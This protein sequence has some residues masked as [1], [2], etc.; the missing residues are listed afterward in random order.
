MK[1]VVILGGGILG[2][3]LQHQS[4]WNLL[5]RKQDGFDITDTTAFSLLLTPVE[6]SNSYIPKYDTVVNCIANT[7]TYSQ[8]SKRHWDVNYKGVADLTDF[9]NE[10]GIKLVHISTEFVYADNTVPPSE[11]DLPRPANNWYA[12]TKLLGDEYIKLRSNNY[13]ICRE[14]H[15]A[16]PFNY[17]EVW[18]VATSGDTV[19][20]IAE[21]IIT[22]INR[23]ET[24]LFNVG[25]GDKT[26]ND[27]APSSKPIPPPIH[28]PADTR[29]N[30]T[31][32]KNTLECY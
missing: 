11:E 19:D 15:K 27:L 1:R 8:D 25:T 16:N 23:N 7:D 12:Y 18:T 20:K 24:G 17:P 5:S 4:K 22:L 26:L 13:L 6:D 21:I 29:M 30:L 32:L 9:C 28:V 31:K 14:L 2:T 10:W 3:E